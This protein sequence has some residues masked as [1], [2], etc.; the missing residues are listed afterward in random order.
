M[1]TIMIERTIIQAALSSTEIFDGIKVNLSLDSIHRKCNTN[2]RSKHNI[3]SFLQINRFHTFNSQHE[4]PISIEP[5]VNKVMETIMAD[6]NDSSNQAPL[7][8]LTDEDN[9]I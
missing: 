5:S 1:S 3:Y 6:K 2:S 9:I 4:N 8:N 7:G